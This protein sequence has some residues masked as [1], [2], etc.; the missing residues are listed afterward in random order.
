MA[1]ENAATALF[2]SAEKNADVMA[3]APRIVMID[4]LV[5]GNNA[6]RTASSE[7]MGAQITGIIKNK[8]QR[9]NVAPFALPTLQRKPLLLLGTLTA[10][11]S[12]GDA[13]AKNDVYRVCLALIDVQAGKV[14]AK[15]TGRATPE[16]V[17]ATPTPYFHD[18]P[19]WVKDKIT[20]GYISSCQ[21]TKPGEAADPLYLETL[22][23]SI[24][25]NDAILAYDRG[26]VK[27]AHR[28]Y[29]TAAAMPGGDQKR[30]T[31]GLYVTSW[32]LKRKSEA[33]DAF[34]KII[35]RGI[36]DQKIGVKFLFQPTNDSF[37]NNADLR[38]QYDLW[39][40]V[41]AERTLDTQTCLN[42]VGHSGK[43]SSETT[44]EQ[45]LSERRAGTVRSRLV[46][47]EPKL[48]NRL[49]VEGRGSSET[50]VGTGSN[51]MR[52]ALDRRVEFKVE[53]TCL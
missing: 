49:R 13:K 53:K 46:R 40:K 23:T 7:A 43:S 30:V 16:T 47:N 12:A 14:L 26:D 27:Q 5:D 44:D 11:N 22:P 52:D 50:V 51:D 38:S 4:P 41:I 10:I 35:V 15:G 29:R 37:V 2:S 17:D 48:K 6:Q 36:Q 25:L 20:E 8:F 24:M 9:F 33:A 45:M 28:Y 3:N 21:K 1:V 34:G 18:T 32:K 19:T 39:L 31:N 42:I